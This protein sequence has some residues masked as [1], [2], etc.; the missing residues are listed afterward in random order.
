MPSGWVLRQLTRQERERVPERL[1]PRS[2]SADPRR[3]GP[4]D[5]DI[6]NEGPVPPPAAAA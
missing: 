5:E 6:V 2:F 3:I 1:P 4:M